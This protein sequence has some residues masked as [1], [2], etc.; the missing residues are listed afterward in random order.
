MR[1]ADLTT[2]R[3]GGDADV[4]VEPATEAELVEATRDAWDSGDEWLIL[5][6]GSNVVVGDEGF[7]GTVIH[8]VTRG[9]ERVPAGEA[10]LRPSAYLGERG[11]RLRVQA[12]EPW[13][14]VVAHAVANGWAGIEALS[15]IPGSAGAAPIQNIGAYGQEVGSSLV[16]IEF[17]D[18]LSGEVERIPAPALGL[19]YRSSVLKQ[20]RQGLVVAIELALSDDAAG[21]RALSHPIAYAQLAAAMGVRLGARVPVDELRQTVLELRASKGMI[22]DQSDP[23]SVSAGSFFTNPIVGENFARTLPREAPRWPTAPDEP[24]IA[25]PLGLP[26]AEPAVRSDYRVKLSAA[27]LIEHA[28]IG[29]GFALPG[30]RAAISSKHT[31][32]IVNRGGA[33]AEE[34]AELARYVQTRVFSEYGVRLQPEPVLVGVTL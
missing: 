6:G 23:D 29:R 7:E 16:A 15:G 30:S 18:Y 34:V 13:D 9:I 24:D 8:V 32:A 4:V 2:L 28:G 25:V 21:R 27:W 12:G 1:L 26:A 31:L 19:G 20:G 14:D 11:V 3:V 17:L 5:G 10:S 22:W 33:T